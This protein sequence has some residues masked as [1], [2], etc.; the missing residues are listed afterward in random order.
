M[1]NIIVKIE[2]PAKEESKQKNLK[3]FFENKNRMKQTED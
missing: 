3:E 1:L 2:E